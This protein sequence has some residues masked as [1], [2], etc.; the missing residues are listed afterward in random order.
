MTVNRRTEALGV[1][2]DAYYPLFADW[3]FHS[4]NDLNPPTPD[5]D[6]PYIAETV[7]GGDSVSASVP[8]PGQ[9]Q[10]R[11]YTEQVQLMLFVPDA[12][13][14]GLALS[15]ADAIERAVTTTAMALSDGEPVTVANVFVGGFRKNP[16]DDRVRVPVVITY[17][18]TAH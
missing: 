18:Y 14:S 8:S 11:R 9:A 10:Y 15:L 17:T 1:L 16:S 12:S 13:G 5:V 4:A 6:A 7:V 2:R 3:V